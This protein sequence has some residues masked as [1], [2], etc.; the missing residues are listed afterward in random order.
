MDARGDNRKCGRGGYQW[1]S[2]G[3]GKCLRMRITIN[4]TKPL[5]RGSKVTL[6]DGASILA[7]FKY[8]RLPDFYYV[9]GR[10]D[11]QESDCDIVIKIR[12]DGG[13]AKREYGPWMSIS[14][15]VFLPKT[16]E[17]QKENSFISVTGSQMRRGAAG[18]GALLHHEEA[19]GRRSREIHVMSR[20][21]KW[22]GKAVMC[23]SG[24]NGGRSAEEDH[25][26]QH[27]F[28]RESSIHANIEVITT[29]NDVE[30]LT[31][32]ME[33]ER[34]VRQL[35]QDRVRTESESKLVEIPVLNVSLGTTKGKIQ[36]TWKRVVKSG[37]KQNTKKS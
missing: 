34:M 7:I 27:T 13:K 24:D 12:K 30:V 19:Q 23:D 4:V 33:K 9:C 26:S 1:R 16:D 36:S 18:L 35:F 17:I 2:N 28:S 11:H 20:G 37:Q 21:Q 22:K 25:G 15:N 10:L 14:S 32:N 3:M 5:K 8:E 29:N 31:A 6:P